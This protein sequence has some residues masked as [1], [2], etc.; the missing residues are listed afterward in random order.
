LDCFDL[1]PAG[2]LQLRNSKGE[3]IFWLKGKDPEEQP[4]FV[5][6][7][8]APEKADSPE[9]AEIVRQTFAVIA[10]WARRAGMPIFDAKDVDRQIRKFLRETGP[11]T[12]T[13]QRLS[14]SEDITVKVRELTSG[15][16]IKLTLS[17]H[18]SENGLVF[19]PPDFL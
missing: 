4:S 8:V 6:A 16:R 14:R 12:T 19:L 9:K 15:R 1:K 11:P 7:Y 13:A 10:R 17:V 3:L 18:P 5:I 2:G